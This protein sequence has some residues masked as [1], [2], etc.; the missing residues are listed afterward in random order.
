VR[1]WHK[2]CRTQRKEVESA[3]LRLPAKLRVIIYR[4][5]FGGSAVKVQSKYR[6]RYDQQQQV[7][8]LLILSPIKVPWGIALSLLGACDQN[9][10]EAKAIA[11]SKCGFDLTTYSYPETSISGPKCFCTERITI[12]RS[13]AQWYIKAYNSGGIDMPMF[14]LFPSLRRLKVHRHFESTYVDESGLI[15]YPEIDRSMLL[16]CARAFFGQPGLETEV[17]DAED[18]LSRSRQVLTL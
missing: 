7:G 9:Y 18:G 4:R 1:D 5:V 10:H 16:R 17:V 14:K 15:I 2:S 8:T 13:S 11:Y 3:L 6:P 12:K